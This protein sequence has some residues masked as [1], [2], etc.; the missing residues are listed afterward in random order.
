[1]KETGPNEYP[2]AARGG[3]GRGT[4]ESSRGGRGRGDR[5]RAATRGGRGGAAP[6][7]NTHEDVSIAAIAE[8]DTAGA[9]TE[10]SASA[11]DGK[12][13][14]S[15][16]V[17]ADSVP[18]TASEGAKPSLLPEGPPQKTWASIFNQP[19]PAPAPAAPATL[20]Q[21][22]APP[23]IPGENASAAKQPPAPIETV[24]QVAEEA[25]AVSQVPEVLEPP[26]DPLTEDNLEH[27][28]DSSIPP[29]TQTA[30]STIGSDVAV[31][32]TPLPG[33]SQA[34]I[35]RPAIGGYASTAMRAAGMA[36]RSASFQRRVMEQQES[37]VLPGHNSVDRATVQFGS[38]GL[39]GDAADVDDEREEPE[40]RAQPPQQSPQGQ[41]R[42]SLPPAAASASAPAQDSYIGQGMPTPKQAPGLPP[43]NPQQAQAAQQADASH[44]QAYNQ[45]GRYN[46]QEPQSSAQKSYDPF[47]HQTPSG[48]DQYSSHTQGQ[49]QQQGQQGSYGQYSSAPSDYSQYYGSEQ[50]RNAYQNYYG[51]S[52]GQNQSQN[53]QDATGSQQRTSSSLNAGQGESNYGSTQGAQ[54]VSDPC[55]KFEV[56]TLTVFAQGRY[57]DAQG[58]G[59][60]TPAP[61]TGGQ[62][63]QN[64]PSQPGQQPQQHQ[65]SGYGSGFPYGHPYYNSPY[66]TAYQNQF[67]GYSGYSGPYGKQGGMYGQPHG[68]GMNAPSSYDNSSPANSGYNQQSSL[69]SRDSGHGSNSNDYNRGSTQP[70]SVAGGGFGG[71]S[72]YGRTQ[73]GYQSQGQ[74]QSHGHGGYGGQQ[75]SG[76]DELKSYGDSKTGPSPGL[77]QPGRPGSAANSAAGQG[78]SGLPPPQSHQQQQQQQGYSGYPGGFNQSSQYGSGLGGLGGHQGGQQGG[79]GGYGGFNQ[80][81]N[82]YGRGGWGGNYTH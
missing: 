4:T 41:P 7:N 30:A 50:Q 22:A 26:H 70:S 15:N 71:V 64:A 75:T 35:G 53:Q 27:L 79:Y 54:Q 82:Q 29:A 67:G 21:K 37:V 28:P 77:T 3:R 44:Q 34:S 39:N 60:N 68:Y 23:A 78:Q 51:Q 65:Q 19:K 32:G 36:P 56:A 81:Y 38:M 49:S 58:S 47:S 9:S 62:Q 10:T 66:A 12:S 40:T 11:A 72:D 46:Q 74:S 1:M 14:W 63:Q 59:Q 42:A 13:Q 24:P 73:S 20:K 31:K 16:I 69:Q 61:A 45:Y 52:Y 48:F 80:S 8:A 25:S 57:N 18:K 6:P 33:G 17:T 2:V 55:H 76:S 43:A 5:T